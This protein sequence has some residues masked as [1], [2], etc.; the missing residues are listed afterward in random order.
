[1][2]EFIDFNVKI[3]RFGE[4]G[5]WGFLSHL[6]SKEVSTL[7]VQAEAI[8]ARQQMAFRQMLGL[9]PMP[10]SF[11]PGEMEP[12]SFFLIKPDVLIYC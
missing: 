5:T 2:R 12:P 8:E 10:F 11:V 4:S 7:L 6:D 1:M 9:H 3:T